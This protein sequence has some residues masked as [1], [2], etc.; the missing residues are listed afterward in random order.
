M[1]DVLSIDLCIR[2]E[3]HDLRPQ[4]P[5]AYTHLAIVRKHYSYK[6]KYS[7]VIAA[8]RADLC[9]NPGLQVRGYQKV[10]L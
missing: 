3:Q 1:T 5:Y 4:Y 2:H 7:F 8:R 9:E 6:S 10:A